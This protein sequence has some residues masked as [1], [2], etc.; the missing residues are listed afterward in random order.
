MTPRGDPAG[1]FE[2]EVRRVA[3]EL[4]PR[5]RINGPVLLD[6]RERD[7]VFNDGEVI[8]IIEATVSKKKEKVYDDLRKSADLVK[9]LRQKFQEMNFKIWLITQNEV[10]AEQN[11]VVPNVRKISKCP[12]ELCS[13]RIFLSK[14]VDASSYIQLRERYPFGSIRRPEDDR[15]FNVPLDEYISANIINLTDRS[16]SISVQSLSN[17]SST[18]P[19]IYLMVGDFG[20]GKSM[21]LRHLYNDL[22]QK[23]LKGYTTKFPVY[24]NLR[25]HFGQSN[26]NESL[27]RHST[28][29]GFGLPHQLIAAWRAGHC[30][31][32]LD[33]FDEL[34]SSRIVRGVRGLKYARREAMRL[35]KAFIDLHPLDTSIFI[36][37]RQN[38]FDSMEEMKSSLG[39]PQ[40]YIHLT[41][42]EFSPNQIE[43]FLKKKGYEENVPDWLPSRPLILGYL[44]VKGI[45]AQ[46]GRNISMLP[47]DEGWD[48]VIDRICEREARQID[49]IGIDPSAVREFV[50]RLATATRQTNS[51]RGP[52]HLN[53]IHNIF[54]DVFSMPPDEK[55]STLIF[56]MPGLT[57][58]SGQDDTREFIDDDYADACRSGDVA[59]FVID[60]HSAK[61]QILNDIS[62]NM[63]D[64]GTSI[65]ARKLLQ[66]TPKQ[67]SMA[68]RLAVERSAHY[69]AFDIVRI[70]QQLDKPFTENSAQIKDG[71]FTEFQLRSSP[72]FSNITFSECYFNSIEIDDGTSHGPNFLRCQIEKV[73]GCIGPNALPTFLPP[74]Y[75]DISKYEN[76]ANTNADILELPIPTSTKVLMTILRKLFVQSGRG[77]KENAFYRGLDT[78]F[79]VYVPDVLNIVEQTGFA[80][81]HKINGPV[82]WFPNRSLASE[83]HAILQSPQYNKH[84]LSI[85]VRNL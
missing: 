6:G 70:M 31:I 36:T 75:N 83:A 46:Y 27:I 20:A 73:V 48:Y 24:L 7:C 76:E 39:L 81:P 19:N 35:I 34:S 56:R 22:A 67:I 26:P 18:H 1:L 47:R 54:Q 55:A 51:G 57:S 14:L 37:G 13:Y 8:H 62:T 49:P 58:A 77:R 68:L 12:I 79:K 53:D 2:T 59:R 74:N 45:L 32:F 10:T 80:H 41:L 66:T 84:E 43:E 42:S 72:D 71:F 4:F 38:Y 23:Y 52:I 3:K 9:S 63:G 15:D 30:H 65:S 78:R 40:N 64:L 17:R 33:G 60:P 44:A 28:D 5:A 85:R 16:S 21:T 25:D 29:I 50:D 61:N 82:V 11:S 69:L